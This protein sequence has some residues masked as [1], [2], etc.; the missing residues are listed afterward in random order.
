M[1]SPKIPRQ[2]ELLSP[3]IQPEFTQV[4]RFVSGFFG[5]FQMRGTM[6]NVAWNKAT[7]R[8]DFWDFISLNNEAFEDAIRACGRFVVFEMCSMILFTLKLRGDFLFE[9]VF[10][11]GWSHYQLVFL[12]V[13]FFFMTLFEDI[14]RAHDQQVFNRFFQSQNG[15]RPGSHSS[16]FFQAILPT[17]CLLEPKMISKIKVSTS[18]CPW[19]K[20]NQCANSHGLVW[21]TNVCGKVLIDFYW[22]LARINS[23]EPGDIVLKLFRSRPLDLFSRG[24]QWMPWKFLTSKKTA[25]PPKKKRKKCPKSMFWIFGWNE[26]LLWKILKF[27]RVVNF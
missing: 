20:N 9:C 15:H 14:I 3:C 4:G 7:W 26:G 8:V 2:R 11:M 17:D 23:L 25:P 5:A 1:A 13:V 24:T 10:Q 6:A 19:K 16:D 12:C 21:T 27:R 22:F 18:S